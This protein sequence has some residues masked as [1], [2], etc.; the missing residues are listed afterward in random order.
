MNPIDDLREQFNRL[1][2]DN[3]ITPEIRRR[4]KSQLE[5]W[6]NNLNIVSREEFDAQTK[7]LQQTQQQLVKLEQALDDLKSQSQ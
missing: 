7:V 3:D 1:F 4:F 6:L 2:A 5:G